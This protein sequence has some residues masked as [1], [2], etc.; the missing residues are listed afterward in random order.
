[1][2]EG[3]IKESEL[4]NNDVSTSV[5]NEVQDQK[6]LSESENTEQ[7]NTSTI[8][9][10]NVN[11]I[12]IQPND[13]EMLKETQ[14][15]D[16]S[17]TEKI[18]SDDQETLKEVENNFKNTLKENENQEQESFKDN[19]IL[20]IDDSEFANDIKI[21]NLN[22][23]EENNTNDLEPT[24]ENNEDYLEQTEDNDKHKLESTKEN[25]D[26]KLYKEN[27]SLE[28]SKETVHKNK[29]LVICEEIKILDN[30]ARNRNQLDNENIDECSQVNGEKSPVNDETT[31]NNFDN[32]VEN[33]IKINGKNTE[34]NNIEAQNNLNIL[35]SENLSAHIAENGCNDKIPLI[36]ESESNENLNEK[37]NGNINQDSNSNSS[38]SETIIVTESIPL[39]I[40]GNNLENSE[41]KAVEPAQMI[42]VIT[43]QTCD[44]IDSD[45]SEAYLTPN[46]LNDTPKKVLEKIN[47]SDSI[48]IVNVDSVSQSIP[49]TESNNEVKTPSKN[50][51]ETLIKQ[52]T[53]ENN[54]DDINNIEK[55]N[56]VENCIETE[57][58][59]KENLNVVLQPP[60]E[61]NGN[62]IE[63]IFY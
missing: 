40:N 53:D 38:D 10:E 22:L 57:I 50:A 14:S 48:S 51:L 23:T 33:H 54:T 9:E 11:T 21:Y 19:N 34:K 47:L 25:S 55:K 58:E 16:I 7:K 17:S 37:M 42:S 44:T 28:P 30:A 24:K 36:I 15:N 31:K 45:C 49:S 20:T 5:Q 41:Q 29:D 60:T 61:H 62:N 52:K 12:K 1:M 43:I 59:V 27:N 2:K 3:E 56:T 18:N 13:Q 4:P 63:G 39:E 46:E 8:S 35:L 32:S 6:S 26:I